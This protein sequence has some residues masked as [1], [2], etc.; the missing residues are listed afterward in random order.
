LIRLYY[1]QDECGNFDRHCGQR[2]DVNKTGI[3]GTSREA[4]NSKAITPSEG[5]PLK[6]C[7]QY[8]LT[9]VLFCRIMILIVIL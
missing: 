2:Y 9:A 1:R 4:D 3:E 6:L 5:M 7:G 8:L